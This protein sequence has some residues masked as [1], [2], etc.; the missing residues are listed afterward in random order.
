MAPITGMPTFT[1]S[2]FDGL[3][4]ET[5]FEVADRQGVPDGDCT[6]RRNPAKY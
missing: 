1:A 2:Q 5:G 6:A 3:I 4:L